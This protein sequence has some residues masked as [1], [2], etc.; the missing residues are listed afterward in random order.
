M[1]INME[2]AN[3]LGISPEII[4]EIEHYH[5][6]RDDIELEM[7]EMDVNSLE[8]KIAL[9]NWHKINFALQDLWGFKQDKFKHPSWTLPFCKCPKMDNNDMGCH[10]YIS[11]DCPIHGGKN[12][13]S[14][15]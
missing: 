8:F 13:G 11:A 10:M 4:K 5:Q 6:I 2:L 15:I 3:S 7:A 14:Q 9:E 1:A 12:Y